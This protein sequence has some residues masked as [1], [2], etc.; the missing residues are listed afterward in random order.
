MRDDTTFV[1]LEE[2]FLD[3]P[4]YHFFRS[5]DQF[6]AQIAIAMDEQGV[7]Q[8][9][10]ARRLGVSRQHISAFMADPGNPTMQTM[11]EMAHALGLR[12]NIELTPAEAPADEAPEAEEAT[13]K[14]PAEA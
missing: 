12:L 4:E 11:V 1:S 2:Q 5:S 7:S 14:A 3:D 9:E 8:S 13:E 6:V 10:L